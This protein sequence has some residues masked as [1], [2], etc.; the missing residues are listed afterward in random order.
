MTDWHDRSFFKKNWFK[1]TVGAEVDR[2]V[3]RGGNG[4]KVGNAFGFCV[5]GKYFWMGLGYWKKKQN[6]QI[7]SNH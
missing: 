5:G 6:R 3:V 2:R 4:R 7:L 1:L